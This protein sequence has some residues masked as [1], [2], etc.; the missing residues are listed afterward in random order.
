MKTLARDKDAQKRADAAESL[1]DMGAWDAVPALA[2]ALKDPSADVRIAATY[3]LTKLKDHAQEA[4]PALKEM[5]GDPNSLVR[6][7][8]VVALQNMDAATHG[9]A[10]AG[11]GPAAGGPRQGDPRERPQD[12]VQRGPAGEGGARHAG[13]RAGAGPG[14]GAA[15]GL[16]RAVARGREARERALGA[17]AGGA[18]HAAGPQ[19][20]G[21]QGAPRPGHRP[22]GPAAL[23]G[24]HRAVHGADDGRPRP[25]GRFRRRGRA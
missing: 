23:P 4:V 19:G 12:A 14:G 18:A 16:R 6:Y 11:P 10:D 2:A 21:C 3:A 15:R 17:R 8:A 13:R 22:A 1:G 20:D 5:L 25:G 9:R 24:R 7:N